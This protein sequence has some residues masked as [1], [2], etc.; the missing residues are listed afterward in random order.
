[1]YPLPVKSVTAPA[2]SLQF[3]GGRHH[4]SI[5]GTA[6]TGLTP[7]DSLARA[8]WQWLIWVTVILGGTVG[9]GWVLLK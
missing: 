4:S 8:A 1:M 7:A 6:Q 2:P 9:V 3:S 5:E